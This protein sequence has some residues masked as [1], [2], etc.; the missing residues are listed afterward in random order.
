MGN[1]NDSKDIYTKNEKEILSDYVKGLR[2]K[3]FIA[4][5]INAILCDDN[6][7]LEIVGTRLRQL[8]FNIKLLNDSLLETKSDSE[9]EEIREQIKNYSLEMAAVC[10]AI[11]RKND[12][13]IV[14]YTI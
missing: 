9:E 2:R 14:R 7:N 1:S 8:I 13:L 3:T 10:Y 6:E 12:H 4:E 5:G 11:Y